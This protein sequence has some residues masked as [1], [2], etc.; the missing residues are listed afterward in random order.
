MEE[1]IPTGGPMPP[2]PP[3]G[4]AGPAAPWA[5]EKKMRW[6]YKHTQKHL[7]NGSILEGLVARRFHS[8]QVLPSRPGE[9]KLHQHTDW[10]VDH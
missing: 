1:A 7:S 2:G 3:A 6:V 8:V 9:E 5:T 4:P 10:V